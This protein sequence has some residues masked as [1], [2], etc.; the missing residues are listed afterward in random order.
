MVKTVSFYPMLKHRTQNLKLH[1]FSLSSKSQI[2]TH[3]GCSLPAHRKKTYH[4]PTPQNYWLNQINGHNEN[5]FSYLQLY[6]SLFLD[7][8]FSCHCWIWICQGFIAMIGFAF[9]IFDKFWGGFLCKLLEY[10]SAHVSFSFF[11]FIVCQLWLK[12]GNGGF[13]KIYKGFIIDDCTHTINIAIKHVSSDGVDELRTKVMLCKVE[14]NQP[15]CWLYSV[16]IFL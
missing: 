13:S 4:E 6:F 8:A 16:P 10:F 3:V 15:F 14:F 2:K 5:A 12:C 9:S 11:L 1:R 7:F